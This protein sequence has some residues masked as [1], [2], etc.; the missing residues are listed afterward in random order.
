MVQRCEW[1]KHID[2]KWY[3]ERGITVCD[4]WRSDFKSFFDWAISNGY[5]EGL[6]LDRIDNDIGY[7]P[8]NCRFVTPKEQANNRRTNIMVEH[9]GKT[10]T[11]KQWAEELGINYHLLYDRFVVRDLTFDEAIKKQ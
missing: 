4:E 7:S 2:H 1:P 11:L 6:T 3:S 10:M 9:D 8:E 5:K